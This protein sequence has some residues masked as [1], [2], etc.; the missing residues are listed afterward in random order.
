VPDASAV[1]DQVFRTEY[2]RIVATLVR[3][4]GDIDDAEDAASEAFAVAATR[5]P[6]DGIPPNPG[7]WLMT[8]ARNRGIDRA[9][10]EAKRR[11]RYERARRLDDSTSDP[12]A[13]FDQADGER[14]LPDDRLRLVFTC[15]HPALAPASQV[16]LTL[17]LLGGMTTPE[18][19]RAFLVAEPTMAQRIVRAKS[20]IRGARIPYRVPGADELPGRLPAVLSVVY[21]IYTEGHTATAGHDLGRADLSAEAIRLGRLLHH[22]MP[23]EPEVT[24]LLALML[25][26]ESRR[27]SRTNPDGSLVLL[28]DQDRG[29]W[30][31]ELIQQGQALV[32][33]CLRRNQPGPYQLQ[34]AIQAVHS[35]APSAAQT[36]WLQIVTLYRHLESIAP[37]PVVTLNRA[38]AEAEADGP[39]AGLALLSDLPLATYAPYHAVLGELLVRSHQHVAA[40]RAFEQAASLTANDVERNHL[41]RRAQQ[42]A[43]D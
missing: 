8:T 18:V 41:L 35:S 11:E 34:A 17:K 16:A 42:A 22:L 9:R 39:A 10:R 37:S 43:K 31:R 24:G 30:D 7:G 20:K 2:G 36:D 38:V 1:L 13:E 32:R 15:C 5:W 6:I 4:L 29:R 3:V 23:Q 21:L 26:A 12:F 33:D 25:L 28:P 27:A 40:A 19:A 14:H